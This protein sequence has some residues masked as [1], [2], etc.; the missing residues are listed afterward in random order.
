MSEVLKLLDDGIAELH[1][2]LTIALAATACPFKLSSESLAPILPIL[3]TLRA[4]NPRED[5]GG[6]WAVSLVTR[7]AI[8]LETLVRS[9]DSEAQ[10]AKL[11]TMIEQAEAKRREIVLAGM[12]GTET[13]K[14]EVWS[15]LN[16]EGV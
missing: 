4:Y 10:V 13:P 6:A 12:N 14:T 2:K 7:T 8:T 11:R 3:A 5:P 9:S 15:L 16:D 1:A